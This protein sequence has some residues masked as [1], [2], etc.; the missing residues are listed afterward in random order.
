MEEAVLADSEFSIMGISQKTESVIG[1][2][3]EE[4]HALGDWL[5]G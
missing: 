3:G 1:G 5:E 4:T 2:T